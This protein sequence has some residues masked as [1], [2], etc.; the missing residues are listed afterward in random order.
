MLDRDDDF[1]LSD[2]FESLSDCCGVV[3][4]GLNGIKPCGGIKWCGIIFGLNGCSPQGLNGPLKGINGFGFGFTI[5]SYSG[6]IS[7]LFFLNGVDNSDTSD[8]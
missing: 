8:K 4:L 1:E 6:V 5:I 3:I 7:L 2:I